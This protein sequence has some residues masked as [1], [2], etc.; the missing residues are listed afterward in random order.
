MIGL[1][2]SREVT[3]KYIQPVTKPRS[4]DSAT[5]LQNAITLVQHKEYNLAKRLLRTVLMREANDV[6]ALKWMGICLKE[7]NQMPEAIRCFRALYGILKNSEGLYFYAESLYLSGQDAEA[8]VAYLELLS[9]GHLLVELSEQRLF[10]AYK[11]LGNIYVRSG[12]FDAADE[13]YN[14][15]YTLQ[16]T[17]DVLMVN[18]GT[19]EIQRENLAAAVERFRQAVQLNSFNDRAWVGLAMVHR[20]MG[21]FDLSR[22]NLE[23]A[24]DINPKNKT[25]LMLLVE[26]DS[27]IQNFTSSV[28]RLK[29]YMELEGEDFEMGF[30]L[31]K[32]LTETGKIEEALLE[33]ERVFNF[34]PT[35]EGALKLMTLLQIEKTKRIL[36]RC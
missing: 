28:E 22:A 20:Q 21:D 34:D 24:I 35:V 13:T 17:S 32:I 10:E 12:D 6:Q 9:K 16:S 31:A 2:S 18:Y 1:E 11:N 4:V 8:K 19:L 25:A 14:K 30:I 26:W 29:K 15:A 7:T 23:R 33:M 5:L 27:Q 3:K 36:T